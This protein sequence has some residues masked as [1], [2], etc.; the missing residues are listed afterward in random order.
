MF[1]SKTIRVRCPKD[2]TS[3][4]CFSLTSLTNFRTNRINSTRTSALADFRTTLAT[5]R[6]NLTRLP[7]GVKV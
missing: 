6:E 3:G 4:L 7:P 1:V 5:K 2:S